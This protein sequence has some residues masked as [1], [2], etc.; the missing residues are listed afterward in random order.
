MAS[1]ALVVWSDAR[2]PNGAQPREQAFVHPKI[3]G[4]TG[5]AVVVRQVR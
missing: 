2:A 3:I 5:G 1:T 4:R